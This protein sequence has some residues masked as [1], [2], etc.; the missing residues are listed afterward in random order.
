M[1]ISKTINMLTDTD[2]AMN[3]G[4]VAGGY[5]FAAVANNVAEGFGP[6]LPNELYGVASVAGATYVLSGT[7]RKYAAAGGALYTVDALAQRVGVKDT[8]TELGA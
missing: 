1:A 3:V 6:D 2:F 5:A 7:D 8:V 4:F